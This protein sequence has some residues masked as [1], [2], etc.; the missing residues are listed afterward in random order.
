MG[1]VFSA[2]QPWWRNVFAFLFWVMA[3]SSF[4][5]ENSF[6]SYGQIGLVEMPTAESAPDGLI[7]LS[8]SYFDGTLRTTFTS[9]IFPRLSASFRYA[10]H[11]KNGEQALGFSNWDRSF[12]VRFR[13]IDEGNVTPAFAIGLKDFIGTG[14]YSSEYIVATKSHK[15]LSFSLGL[16]FGRLAS[17]GGFSNPL[18]ALHQGFK[19]RENRESGVG[20][21]IEAAQWFQGNAAIFG[22]IKIGVSDRLDAKLEYSND[23]YDLEQSYFEQSSP[24]NVSA[25][26]RLSDTFSLG[27]AWLHGSKAALS[28][29]LSLDPKSPANGP[30]L[31]LTPTPISPRSENTGGPH[32]KE[33]DIVNLQKVL[34]VDGL[35]LKRIEQSKNTVKLSIENTK[36]RS[37]IQALGRV[38]QT[39]SRFLADSVD[40]ITVELVFEGLVTSSVTVHRDKLTELALSTAP[41]SDLISHL[42]IK[43]AKTDIDL[44]AEQARLSWGIAPYLEYSLFDPLAPI[45]GEVGVKFTSE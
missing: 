23:A 31:E 30:S 24:W 45:M 39:A 2:F 8:Q 12:D 43:D 21:E 27:V 16:G 25:Q 22:G 38:F 40:F 3:S 18:G 41:S 44:V 33:T 15:N 29:H 17:Y 11:G 36:Y 26:Y 37:N 20:G 7:T 34:S 4:A 9:Q 19:V 5:G 10:G 14:R 35:F 42:E 6:N 28:A 13:F 1:L 32:R